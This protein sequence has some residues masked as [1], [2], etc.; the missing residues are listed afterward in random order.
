M[1]TFTLLPKERSQGNAYALA[2]FD[3]YGVQMYRTPRYVP[4][5][6]KKNGEKVKGWKAL[7]KYAVHINKEES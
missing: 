1:Q 4:Y 7:Y 6:L 5:I 3:K 2:V